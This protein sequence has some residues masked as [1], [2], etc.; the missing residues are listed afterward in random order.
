M[1]IKLLGLPFHD[2]AS[3]ACSAWQTVG[4]AAD[5]VVPSARHGCR[6][7]PRPLSGHVQRRSSWSARQAMASVTS[8][9]R[10]GACSRLC[11]T[12][13]PIASGQSQAPLTTAPT[14]PLTS[15]PLTYAASSTSAAL[16]SSD[17]ISC[18]MTAFR[19]SSMRANRMMGTCT[20][21]P[22]TWWC[23]EMCLCIRLRW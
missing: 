10:A 16:T 9:R 17:G 2:C 4:C 3:L 21:R 5:S 15:C 23:C 7:A 14:R 20:T 8:A 19:G 22:C 18:Q 1:P 11:T 13:S 6:C 12:R